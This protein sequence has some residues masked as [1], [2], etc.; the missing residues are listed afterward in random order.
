VAAIGAKLA[1]L[2]QLGIGIALDDFGVGYSSL[3]YLRHLQL[4]QLKIDRSFVEH[5]AT[6]AS[7]AAIA[8][9]IVTLAQTLGLAVVAEGVET[10]QQRDFLR[11]HGCPLHQ[12]F[13]YAHPL[14]TPD[15]EAYVQTHAA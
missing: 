7:D 12:G 4:D 15:F 14:P 6:D 11:R 8:R 3:S 13:L 10:V 9:T 2:R 1:A 5:I